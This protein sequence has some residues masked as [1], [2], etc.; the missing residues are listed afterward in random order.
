M[1]F[2]KIFFCF[3]K[4]GKNI[5]YDFVIFLIDLFKLVLLNLII[6]FQF[7]MIGKGYCNSVKIVYVRLGIENYIIQ[8]NFLLKIEKNVILCGFNFWF[9]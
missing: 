1:F 8:R 3:N 5:I 4:L 6:N 7:I 9:L 2:I